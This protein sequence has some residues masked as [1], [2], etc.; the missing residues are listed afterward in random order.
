M[1]LNDI[2]KSL[3]KDIRYYNDSIKEVALEIIENGISEYP[4]F[5]AHKNTISLGEMILNMDDFER[6]WSVN[7]TIIDELIEKNIIAKDKSGEFKKIFKDPKQNICIFLV[8][9]EYANFIFIPYK[10]KSKESDT[11]NN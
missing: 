8:T 7:A 10:S 4:I 11:N 9:E 3:E 2:L 6:E 1:E 5:V